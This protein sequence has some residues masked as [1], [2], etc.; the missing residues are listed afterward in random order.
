MLFVSGLSVFVSR[1]YR[2]HFGDIV[3][4][5]EVPLIVQML[6]ISDTL[7]LKDYVKNIFCTV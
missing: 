2:M 1:F 3:R 4:T 7:L 6:C 5:V